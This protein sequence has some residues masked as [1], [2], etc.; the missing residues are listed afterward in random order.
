MKKPFK[1]WVKDVEQFI[2]EE[3]LLFASGEDKRFFIT[4]KAGPNVNRYVV[5]NMKTKEE[6]G[7]TNKG[8]AV[9]YFNDLVI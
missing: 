7:F 1:I 4:L 8:K 3:R 2:N 5:H 9:K 6:V